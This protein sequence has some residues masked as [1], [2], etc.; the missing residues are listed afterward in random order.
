MHDKKHVPTI[1]LRKTDICFSNDSRP[2][3]WNN[4]RYA[5]DVA[6][7]HALVICPD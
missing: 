2:E 6:I 1:N 4:D 7:A 3:P 5:M